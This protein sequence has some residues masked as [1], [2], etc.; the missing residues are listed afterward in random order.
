MP[1]TASADL[2]G[3]GA[4]RRP[5]FLEADFGTGLAV[6]DQ[7]WSSLPRQQSCQFWAKPR[8]QIRTSAF[9][10]PALTMDE[11]RRSR[12]PDKGAECGVREFT[13]WKLLHQEE[14]S[15]KPVI[16]AH[17]CIGAITISRP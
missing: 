11:R 15:E 8:T 2:S 13:G 5:G 6:G 7:Q 4:S 12:Q 9:T 10:H 16:D 3:V 14:L 1:D 17:R